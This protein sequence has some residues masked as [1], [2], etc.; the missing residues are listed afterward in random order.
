MRRAGHALLLTQPSHKQNM[1]DHPSMTTVLSRSDQSTCLVSIWSL[2]TFR[3]APLGSRH[4]AH[5]C[6]KSH[7]DAWNRIEAHLLPLAYTARQY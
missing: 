2:P 3:P 1:S 6:R 5:A 7:W 4:A